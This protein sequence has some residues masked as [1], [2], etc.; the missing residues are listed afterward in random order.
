M[1]LNLTYLIAISFNLILFNFVNSEKLSENLKIYPLPNNFILLDFKFTSTI[2]YPNT[3]LQD[4]QLLPRALG[5]LIPQ[6]NLKELHLTFT[7]GRWLQN[8]WDLPKPSTLISNS[9][10]QLTTYFNETSETLDLKSEKWKKLT[11]TLSGIFCNSLGQIDTTNSLVPKLSF[12]KKF[13]GNESNPILVNLPLEG[14][15]TENLTPWIKLLP[16]RNQYGIG[17]LLS[18]ENIFESNYLSMGLN[19]KQLCDD[20]T[21][22]LEN[23]KLV[24]NQQFSIVL[25]KSELNSNNWNFNSLL[26]RSISEP[27]KLA[28]LSQVIF[29]DSDKFA[30]TPNPTYY[31]TNNRALFNFMEPE[32]LGLVVT[33]KSKDSIGKEEV[34]GI[35]KFRAIRYLTKRKGLSQNLHIELNNLNNPKPLKVTL[36]ETLPWYLKVYLHTLTLTLN[37]KPALDLIKKQYYQPS[38]NRVRSS[39]LELELELP[40]ESK[41]IIEYGLDMAMLRYTEYPPDSSK[42][43]ILPGAIITLEEVNA[44]PGLVNNESIKIYTDSLALLLRTPDFSMPYNVIMLTC[45]LLAMFFGFMFNSLQREFKVIG[46]NDQK[47]SVGEVK[48]ND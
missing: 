47:K 9:G 25:D 26:K 39:L 5:Q 12:K 15:C 20:E 10:L 43:M 34:N 45:T 3:E 35:D 27:C 42:G 30:F 38:K 23:S 11:S 31:L 18:S 19:F 44:K 1:K 28:S 32:N 7:R 22:N 33:D 48:K 29:F 13:L 24:L 2:K 46:D 41:V 17:S 8:Y 4:Y 36:L 14:T 16:C 37:G 21:C 6:L 40:A